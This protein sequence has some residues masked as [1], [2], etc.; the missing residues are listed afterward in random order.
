MSSAPRLRL[1]S[2]TATS[3]VL[4]AGPILGVVVAPLVDDSPRDG[5]GR[6]RHQKGGAALVA[7]LSTG[8]V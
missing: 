8:L 6:F 7:V 3:G 1:K 2:S 5:R 4:F